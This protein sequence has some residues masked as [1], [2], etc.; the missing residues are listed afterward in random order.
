MTT[1]DRLFLTVAGL[2]LPLGFIA[3]KGVAVLY[4]LA[5]VTMLWTA[6]KDD[7]TARPLPSNILSAAA[8]FIAWA[9]ISSL[10]SL[11]GA[12]SLNSAVHLTTLLIG[13]PVLVFLTMRLRPSALAIRRAAMAYCVATIF[14][15]ALLILDLITNG[16][17]RTTLMT[18]SHGENST[19][20]LP[21]FNPGA[22][23]AAVFTLPGAL[24]V[25]RTIGPVFAAV[26]LLVGILIVFVSNSL[27]AGTGLAVAILATF[28][29]RVAGRHGVVPIA[30]AV[31]SIILLM[32]AARLVDE[33]PFMSMRHAVETISESNDGF[34]LNKLSLM[35]MLR[36]FVP[37]IEQDSNVSTVHRVY[38]YD[39]V[40][41]R[42]SERPFLGWG[43]DASQYL[44]G[45]GDKIAEL[46][47][48][49][50]PLHPH[51]L[52]LQTWVELGVIGAILLAAIIWFI[53][54]VIMR[55]LQGWTMAVMTGS[56]IAY[57]VIALTAYKAW[58]S[59]W[60]S[61]GILVAAVLTPMLT[62]A[63]KISRNKAS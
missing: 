42:I 37:F 26:V 2:I 44:P 52:V 59:W 6:W 57:F 32:P 60:I 14:V 33:T 31:I 12:D 30:V 21:T 45:G 61:S 63:S 36:D 54:K 24:L 23:I 62:E 1:T 49:Y 50:L 7:S 19:G 47:R 22:T 48:K 9:G 55:H 46:D 29:V 40:L 53:F 15:L 56:L 10:W 34:F 11:I 18:I 58:A 8:L 3:Y 25:Y 4:G 17:V 51:N 35:H 28:L 41:D 20:P 5:L 16:L 13:G 39:F 43:M 27:S 38:V